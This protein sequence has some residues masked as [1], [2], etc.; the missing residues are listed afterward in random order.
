MTRSEVWSRAKRILAVRLDAL[1]DVLMTGPALRA[2]KSSRPGRRI[3]LLTSAAGAEGAALLPDVEEV[4]VYNAPWMKATGPR[5]DS[6]L[7]WD[8]IRGLQRRFDAAV[9]FTVYSQSSLPAALFCYLAEIPLR[10]AHCR[11]NPY[12]LLTD[13]MPETEPHQQ[14]RHE[15]A[16]Q[17]DLVASVGCHVLDHRLSIHIPKTSH[18][19]V[20]SHVQKAGLDPHLPWIVLHPG[21]SAPS[22]RYPPAQFAQAARRLVLDV[23]MQ[24]L[25]TGSQGE[26]GL[27]EEIQNAMGVPSFSLVGKLSVNELAALI[28]MAPL[29]VA[30]N[31]GPVHIAAA[32]GTPVVVLYA[33]TNPQHT[34]WAVVHRV[35]NHDVSC[36]YCYNSICPEVH[37]N[38]LALVPPESIVEAVWSILVEAGRLAHD[39]PTSTDATPALMSENGLAN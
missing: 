24:V 19:S 18:E 29:L 27:I 31:T 6:E 34:P 36:K 22:R 30:N 28:A 1:G 14:I 33:L 37:N 16:R 5:D 35:L 39:T 26:S 9:I 25:L 8:M 13:W 38:C 11:E 12:Q 4:I 21:A 2:L 3:T 20:L 23:G 15:V 32:V 17:L 7:D 10:L